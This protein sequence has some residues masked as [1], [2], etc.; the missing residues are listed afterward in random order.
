MSYRFV[1]IETVNVPAKLL[2]E[3]DILTDPI[4]YRGTVE[5]QQSPSGEAFSGG[6][7]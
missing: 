3:F 2:E 7:W 1:V 6:N 5:T 4:I